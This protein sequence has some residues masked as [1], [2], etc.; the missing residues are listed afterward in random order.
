VR[1]VLIYGPPAA[2]KLTVARALAERYDLILLDNHLTFDVAL[3]VFPFGSPAFN[4][5]VERLRDVLLEE[6]AR[7]GRDTVATFV[8]GA[9]V[10]R[11]Y[12][13]RLAASALALGVELHRVQFCPPPEIVLARVVAPS[14]QGTDKIRDA[15]TLQGVIDAHDL[16]SPIDA[17]D[18]CIDNTDLAPEAVAEMIGLHIGL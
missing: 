13:A 12:V 11:P 10:D 5:L 1:H 2:G 3:R 8:F 14:R 4:H 15:T 17:T 18:L 6:T 7:A 9:D 16:Y